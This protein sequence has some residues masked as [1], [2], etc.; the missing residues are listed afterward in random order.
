[1]IYLPSPRAACANLLELAQTRELQL[2]WA[3]GD[4]HS[5]CRWR[6]SKMVYNLY[7]DKVVILIF[8]VPHKR[9]AKIPLLGTAKRL[10]QSTMAPPGAWSSSVKRDEIHNHVLMWHSTCVPGDDAEKLGAGAYTALCLW[11]VSPRLLADSCRK[12]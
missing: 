12:S 3:S 4:R 6:R 7:H 11:K 10:G 1:M 2:E 5:C 9:V 8:C